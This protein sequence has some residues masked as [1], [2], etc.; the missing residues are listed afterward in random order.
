M[1]VFSGN[2]EPLHSPVL[3]KARTQQSKPMA[4]IAFGNVTVY[5]TKEELLERLFPNL[6]AEL[7]RTAEVVQNQGKDAALEFEFQIYGETEKGELEELK[8]EVER[9]RLGTTKTQ[10]PAQQKIVDQDITVRALNAAKRHNLETLADIASFTSDKFL[11]LVG[12]KNWTELGDLLE[13]K[14]LKF[15]EE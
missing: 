6:P 9:L 2:S 8:K 15:K 1:L 13:A 3:A 12:R 10:G 11:G 4:S 14:G 5:L 7:K